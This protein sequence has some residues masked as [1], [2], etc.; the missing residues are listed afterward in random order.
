MVVD[1]TWK[2]LSTLADAYD[3]E[4]GVP[5]D[6]YDFENQVNAVEGACNN[7]GDL[8]KTPFDNCCGNMKCKGDKGKKTCRC[9]KSDTRNRLQ[10]R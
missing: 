4:D 9:I 3:L 5:L 10:H 6:P 2:F 7:V 8:S 1:L